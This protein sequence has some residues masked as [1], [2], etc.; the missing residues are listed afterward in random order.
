MIW[1]SFNINSNR[2]VLQCYLLER[3]SLTNLSKIA[4]L[5]ILPLRCFIF[6]LIYQHYIIFFLCI[7]CLLQLEYKLLRPVNVSFLATMLIHV[8][9]WP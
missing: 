4:A 8:S 3:P 1:N 9:T 5:S 6:I 2:P 7:I